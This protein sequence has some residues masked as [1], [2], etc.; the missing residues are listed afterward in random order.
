[1]SE[2]DENDPSEHSSTEGE[3]NAVEPMYVYTGPKIIADSKI[4]LAE[5]LER[6]GW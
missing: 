3:E 4:R 1:M 5:W 6:R 2:I